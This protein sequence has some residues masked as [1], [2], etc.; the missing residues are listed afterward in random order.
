MQKLIIL[1][2][3]SGSGKS[4][5]AKRLQENLGYQTMLIPQDV[6]RREILKTQD[7]PDNP[8]IQLIG[9]MAAYGGKIGYDVIM[10]GIMTEERYG[11]ML[12]RLIADFPGSAHVYYFDISFKETLRRHNKKANKH[13]FGEHE[14]RQW[15]VEKD[16]LHYPNEQ[17]ITDKMSELDIDTKI[18]KDIAVSQ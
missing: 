12:R 8:A 15:W 16:I 7:L 2:G 18:L 4:S 1:R 10:E 13:E 3:N 5:A 14:M 11:S 17:F 6:V 9:D